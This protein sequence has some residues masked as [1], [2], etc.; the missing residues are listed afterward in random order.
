MQKTVHPR[1][2]LYWDEFAIALHNKL[3]EANLFGLLG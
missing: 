1:V 2:L 3:K